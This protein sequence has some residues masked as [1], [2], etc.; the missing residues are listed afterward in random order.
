MGRDERRFQT[1]CCGHQS[2]GEGS[3]ESREER[4]VSEMEICNGFRKG[5][6]NGVWRSR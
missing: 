3:G 2:E 4:Q 6:L 5:V 1:R